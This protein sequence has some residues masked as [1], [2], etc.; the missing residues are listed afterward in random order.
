MENPPTRY[1][2]EWPSKGYPS[3]DYLSSSR[4]RLA[5]QLMFKEGI[6]NAWGKKIAVAVQRPFFATLPQLPRVSR[7]EAEIAWMIYDL[8]H[9]TAENRYQ[10]HLSE[11]ARSL[12]SA[13]VSKSA[14]VVNPTDRTF[15][16]GWHRE[17]DCGG[18]A[19]GLS[20]TY[21]G[22][23]RGRRHSLANNPT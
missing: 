4:K 20:C 16:W 17:F 6:L 3:P 19:A 14:R 18:G 22:T 23:R 13:M 5:P 1:A 10:L 9:N 11:V 15:R 2:M 12:H 21:G 7:S 8:E